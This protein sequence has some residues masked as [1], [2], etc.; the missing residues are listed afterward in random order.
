M[1]KVLVPLIDGFEEIE[2]ITSIDLLRRAGI[3]VTTAG[4]AKR[5]ATGSHQ[6]TVETDT[7]FDPARARD[8][9]MIL[10]PGGPGTKNLAAVPGLDALLKEFAAAGKPLA[11]I[12]AAPSILAKAGLLEGKRAVCFPTVESAMTGARLSHDPVAV[13]GNIITSRGAGTAVP[14]ALAV[15]ALL[16]GQ[17]KADEIA[18]QIMYQ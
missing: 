18:R 3:E 11:A 5:S 4:I 13:D 7:L 1:K 14:F 15:I 12:C 2:A 6:L 10:L 16:L 17:A 8:A 9:D